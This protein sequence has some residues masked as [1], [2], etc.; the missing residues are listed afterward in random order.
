MRDTG[1]GK[2]VHTCMAPG[3]DIHGSA[4]L[5]YSR[6]V[7][8]IGPSFT[9]MFVLGAF[10]DKYVPILDLAERQWLRGGVVA[11]CGMVKSRVGLISLGMVPRPDL[12]ITTGFACDAS[13]RTNELA[14]SHLSI[15]PVLGSMSFC[16][17]ELGECSAT[18]RPDRLKAYDHLHRNPVRISQE[19]EESRVLGIAK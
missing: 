7:G 10:F 5:E 2:I 14:S 6:N 3:T 16:G 8:I 12:T 11:H 4:F 17:P 15:L 9:F 18:F 19:L 13:P 1:R